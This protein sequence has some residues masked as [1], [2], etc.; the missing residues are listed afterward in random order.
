[1]RDLVLLNRRVLA[2]LTLL[3]LA[4]LLAQGIQARSSGRAE[5][6]RSTGAVTRRSVV[7]EQ[8]SGQPDVWP[9]KRFHVG[10]VQRIANGMIAAMTRWGLVPHTYV[11]TVRGRRTGRPY[12]TPVT[13]VEVDDAKWLVAPYGPMSWVLNARVAGVVTLTRRGTSVAYALREL[14][15]EE[16]A[17]VLKDYVRVASATRSYFAADKDSPVEEFLDEAHRHPVF[18]LTLA[19]NRNSPG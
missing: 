1:M 6:L 14:T 3:P 5:A 4:R 18:A 10:R 11:M 13:L 19:P 15:P 16:A 8:H 17:P 7:R 2:V 12:S 9:V